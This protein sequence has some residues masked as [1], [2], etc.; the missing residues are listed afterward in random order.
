LICVR[1][2]FSRLFNK[3][4][5]IRRPVL[6]ALWK[7][8]FSAVE[9][10]WHYFVDLTT[11]ALSLIAIANTPTPTWSRPQT[12]TQHWLFDN[13]HFIIIGRETR[14]GRLLYLLFMWSIKGFF[15]QPL[16]PLVR[17]PSGF[18]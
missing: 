8:F 17:L 9:K 11:F 15:G 2:F 3:N 16:S 4:L 1:S 18:L 10:R 5:V 13:G 12:H 14:R 6:P 7:S